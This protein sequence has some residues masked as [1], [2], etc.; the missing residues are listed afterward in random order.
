MGGGT[1]LVRLS[2][3]AREA[4]CGRDESP[5]A[6]Q[7][8]ETKAGETTDFGSSCSWAAARVAGTKL[9]KPAADVSVCVF[10]PPSAPAPSATWPAK[11]TKP[12][13][14][15]ERSGSIDL[16]SAGTW[17][18]RDGKVLN[19]VACPFP[20]ACTSTARRPTTS[21]HPGE[22]TPSE[23]AAPAHRHY[24]HLRHK[25]GEESPLVSRGISATHG[26]R[27]P[28]LWTASRR[29]RGGLRAPRLHEAA[30]Q[31]RQ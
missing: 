14:L 12:R 7:Y 26:R 6:Y 9:P 24:R 30:G 18:G 5:R 22:F 11:R 2:R 29:R 3:C 28:L 10:P 31:A 25:Q 21:Q 20:L 19:A 16:F 15:R 13:R 23:P 27:A 8:C 4:P 17:A 1:V